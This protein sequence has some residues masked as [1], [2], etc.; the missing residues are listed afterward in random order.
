MFH[1]VFVAPQLALSLIHIHYCCLLRYVMYIII[2][3]RHFSSWLN[4]RQHSEFI[5]IYLEKQPKTSQFELCP[6]FLKIGIK[7]VIN[8]LPVEH[9]VHGVLQSVLLF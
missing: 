1:D 3:F 8:I 2:Y 4:H 9:Q 6:L 7:E 5:E